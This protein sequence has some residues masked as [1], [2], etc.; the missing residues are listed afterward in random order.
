MFLPFYFTELKCNYCP[1][2]FMT[3]WAL[4]VHAQ[5]THN[6]KIFLEKASKSL[7]NQGKFSPITDGIK[8]GPY[9]LSTS[10]HSTNVQDMQDKICTTNLSPLKYIENSGTSLTPERDKTDT[11]Y[12]VI[13]VSQ[14]SSSSSNP[15]Q[16]KMGSNII[17]TRNILTG[18]KVVGEKTEL[19]HGQPDSEKI[20]PVV[21]VL[22]NS[23]T[24]T[25]QKLN[26]YPV[27]QSNVLPKLGVLPISVT[28]CQIQNGNLKM[29]P[30]IIP[31]TVTQ[32]FPESTVNT[33]PSSFMT[34]LKKET[35]PGS[36]VGVGNKQSS[37]CL[38]NYPESTTILLPTPVSVSPQSSTKIF[39]PVTDSVDHH[40]VSNSA[41]TAN[42]VK[43]P[44]KEPL[45]SQATATVN[46][47]PQFDDAN[48]LTQNASEKDNTKGNYIEG[49]EEE[50]PPA[51]ECCD[52]QGCGVTVIPGSH[53]NLQECCNAVLPKK[54]KRH[55][56]QK[57]MPFSWSSSRYAR[58]KMLFR[59][60][61]SSSARLTSSQL[62]PKSTAGTIFIDL[63]PDSSNSGEKQADGQEGT[64]FK[65]TQSVTPGVR[66]L[67]SS[68]TSS[69]P[70]SG[71]PVSQNKP[72]SLILKPGAVYSIPF[73]YTIPTSK[74]AS[75]TIIPFTKGEVSFA[76]PLKQTGSSS[77]LAD[78]SD[79]STIT[80]ENENKSNVGRRE[81]VSSLNRRVEGQTV[82]N[83]GSKRS[84]S[85][86]PFQ[87]DKCTMA[88]NQRIHL[89]KHM[90]KHTGISSFFLFLF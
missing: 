44:G 89:K 40:Q 32:T 51:T 34:V 15:G 60:M 53:E 77:T 8:S 75:S 61:S 26:L 59:S 29:I 68:K 37:D 52:S 73:T 50:T 80:T 4:L 38:T 1:Q 28:S 14:P 31:R 79:L 42:P 9:S 5:L 7:L 71:V 27:N 62:V 36:S 2:G 90:S 87:C 57:H 55:M 12:A 25:S 63:E 47:I 6:L 22:P 3:A 66:I 65:V 81:L 20:S 69:V 58:R 39:K 19:N 11:Q 24:S 16:G 84:T 45:E 88:F 85:S 35:S 67:G 74:S 64:A 23:Q 33:T 13:N 76:E 83:V 18:S 21:P 56:E 70:T 48:N 10:S 43:T 30:K 41:N 46:L 86:K 49:V 17:V 54:R 78:I 82:A 72:H